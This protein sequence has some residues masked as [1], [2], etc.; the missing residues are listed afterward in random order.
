MSW[1]K[2]QNSIQNTY[3]K[4]SFVLNCLKHYKWQVTRICRIF[5]I[6]SGQQ[7][8]NNININM[9]SKNIPRCSKERCSR[10]VL[11]IQ[12]KT[13]PMESIFS[14]IEDLNLWLYSNNGLHCSCF[15]VS[16]EGFFRTAFLQIVS[17]W[18]LFDKILHSKLKHHIPGRTKM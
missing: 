16:F 5:Q 12:C 9:E 18:L 13:P 3:G 1:K 17:S 2:F 10:K 15:T 8:F 4:V 6:K 11:K 7:T 14:K